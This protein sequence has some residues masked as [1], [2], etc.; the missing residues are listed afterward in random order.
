MKAK[1][2]QILRSLASQ[3]LHDLDHFQRVANH[4]SERMVH[5]SDQC[6]DLL[7]HALARLHHEFSEE[8]R[9]LFALHEGA[10]ACLHIEHEGIDALGKFLAHDRRANKIRTLD[11]SGYIAQ[12][13]KFSIGR[14]DFC[15]LPDHRA[16][17]DFKH[18]P[19]LSHRQIHIEPWNGF[20]LVESTA[21]V[22]ETSPAD[23]RHSTPC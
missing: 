10:G 4:L 5:V 1:L 23:H 15:R 6:D 9:I 12:R 19:A 8:S 14:G 16:P 3:N 21:G 20:E 18:A 17:T 2:T 7:P 22:A 13:V 11:G